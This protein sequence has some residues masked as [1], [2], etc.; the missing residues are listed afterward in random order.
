MSLET[1]IAELNDTIKR[2]IDILQSA[3]ASAHV[4]GATTAVLSSSL[5]Q[6]VNAASTA[7]ATNPLIN[8]FVMIYPDVII[9]IFKSVNYPIHGQNDNKD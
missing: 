6:P 4:V 1:N 8:I 7:V 2:L 5:P 9:Y 3:P